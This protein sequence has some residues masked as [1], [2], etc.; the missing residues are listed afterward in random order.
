MCGDCFG[1]S[2]YRP[3]LRREPPNLSMHN[4]LVL[5][6]PM[7]EISSHLFHV[8]GKTYIV[9]VDCHSSFIWTDKIKDETTDTVIKY[10]EGIFY[11]FGF[12]KKLRSDNGPYQEE[13]LLTG[14]RNI[15]FTMSSQVPT[16]LKA[17]D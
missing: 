2:E 14:V 11:E 9:M 3:S 15:I 12:P 13:D 10:M 4:S 7:E 16:T 6:Q 1:C 17:L 5:M 8:D